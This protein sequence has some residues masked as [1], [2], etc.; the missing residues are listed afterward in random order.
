MDVYLRVTMFAIGAGM[1]IGSLTACTTD[2]FEPTT[3]TVSSTSGRAWWNE[4]GLI[5]PEHKTIA[6]A[7][8][9]R[10]NL[11]QD[12]ARGQG[13]YLSSIGTLIGVTDNSQPSFQARAQ[14]EFQA[15]TAADHATRIRQ[16]RTL[17]E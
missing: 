11:E 1:I 17:N 2:P 4:D 3:D 15:L 10:A 7:T 6:F 13:E 16:L 14:R 12:I 8:Y 9:N 5:R